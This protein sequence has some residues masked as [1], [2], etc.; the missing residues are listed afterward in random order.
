MK[1]ECCIEWLDDLIGRRLMR[2]WFY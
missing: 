1:P 2:L